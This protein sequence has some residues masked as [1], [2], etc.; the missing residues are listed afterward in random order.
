MIT[1]KYCRVIRSKLPITYQ[2]TVLFSLAMRYVGKDK[3]VSFEIYT[4]EYYVMEE[5]GPGKK[6][7]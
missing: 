3:T 2:E 7:R 5:Q 6:L 1:V 4:S